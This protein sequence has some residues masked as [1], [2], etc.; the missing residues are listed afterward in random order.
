MTAEK[1]KNSGRSQKRDSLF[2]FILLGMS[3]AGCLSG[4]LYFS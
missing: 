1:P 4:P 3:M 2:G